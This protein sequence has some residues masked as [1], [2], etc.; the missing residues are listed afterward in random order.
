MNCYILLKGRIGRF[1]EP[2]KEIT[3]THKDKL[4]TTTSPIFFKTKATITSRESLISSSSSDTSSEDSSSSQISVTK[5]THLSNKYALSAGHQSESKA[6][7]DKSDSVLESDS[8]KAAIAKIFRKKKKQKSSLSEIQKKKLKKEQ[9][10]AEHLKEL[11]SMYGRLANTIPEGEFFGHEL[12]LSNQSTILRE[13]SAVVMSKTAE[14][15]VLTPKSFELFFKKF[16]HRRNMRLIKVLESI[17]PNIRSQ[18][19]TERLNKMTNIFFDIHKRRGK[20]MSKEGERSSRIYIVVDGRLKIS[21]TLDTKKFKK[22]LE[23]Q[24]KKIQ[25]KIEQSEVDKEQ[26]AMLDACL[27]E[28]TLNLEDMNITKSLLIGSLS[29]HDIIGEESL[30]ESTSENVSFFTIQCLTDCKLFMLNAEDLLESFPENLI[31]SLV[32]GYYFKLRQRMNRFNKESPL[33]LKRFEDKVKKID[34][35]NL[36][37]LFGVVGLGEKSNMIKTFI[38]SRIVEKK[39]SMIRPGNK[40]RIA[41]VEAKLVRMSRRT[42]VLRHKNERFCLQTPR[43]VRKIGH[44]EPWLLKEPEKKDTG[45][46]LK[47]A[48]S[49]AMRR[50]ALRRAKRENEA[51]FSTDLNKNMKKIDFL[52]NSLETQ[53]KGRRKRGLVAVNLKKELE[54]LKGRFKSLQMVSRKSVNLSMFDSAQVGA[55]Q[56]KQ[57]GTPKPKPHPNRLEQPFASE[58]RRANN[59]FS[60]TDKGKKL[61]KRL[62]MLQFDDQIGE[63]RGSIS[64]DGGLIT[65]IRPFDRIGLLKDILVE[66]TTLGARSSHQSSSLS[67]SR[68][69]GIGRTRRSMIP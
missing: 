9:K 12:I 59:S 54:I 24:Q 23:E 56:I 29:Q 18:F 49:P 34:Y 42:M 2:R 13:Y 25:E 37:S 31:S 7:T 19:S 53:A 28:L 43:R 30:L 10:A 40:E 20:F 66:S 50:I 61:L 47:S 68:V 21:K 17:F 69:S 64:G 1:S 60:V 6:L 52:A 46:F 27:K 63:V 51:L 22:L 48:Y 33:I 57:A 16:V 41:K 8:I 36:S 35:I 39:G 26:Q 3:T 62:S 44:F 5:I 15:L 58:R 38:K 14:L 11:E 4:A 55:I 65:A 67:R 45:I 32:S